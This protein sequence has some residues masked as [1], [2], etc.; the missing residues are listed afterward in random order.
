MNSK[1][2]KFKRAFTLVEILTAVFLGSIIII[3]AYSVYLMSYKSYQRHAASAELT[4]NA[5]IA[6][7]R[8]TREIRQA[9]DI[10]T[11]LPADAGGAPSAIQ[12]QDGHGI[13]VA[14]AP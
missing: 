7:E 5:R 2:R 4:Q 10:T 9:K 13:V 1:I 3:A 6:L 11:I 12:F 14:G 8:M